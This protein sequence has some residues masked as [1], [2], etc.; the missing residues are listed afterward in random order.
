MTRGRGNNYTLS[1]CAVG[2]TLAVFEKQVNEA[3]GSR[4]M[5]RPKITADPIELEPFTYHKFDPNF[6]FE[7]KLIQ[8][9]TIKP[10]QIKLYGKWCCKAND[11]AGQRCSEKMS[12]HIWGDKKG[13][14]IVYE[15]LAVKYYYCSCI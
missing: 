12:L 2:K 11:I 4:K 13:F 8:T 7:L 6:D 1:S 3:F 14:A 15:T 5:K 9:L 10:G